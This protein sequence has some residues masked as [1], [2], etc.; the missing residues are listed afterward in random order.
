MPVVLAPRRV[1]RSQI[2]AQAGLA[3]LRGGL[4]PRGLKDRLARLRRHTRPNVEMPVLRH[5]GT[6]PA[7]PH[8]ACPLAQ[9]L[10]LRRRLLPVRAGGSTVGIDS[11][12]R[13][14]SSAR[15]H[16]LTA[17]FQAGRGIDFA[18]RN[19]RITSSGRTNKKRLAST[20]T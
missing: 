3:A 20:T 6:G 2:R 15:A 9:R 13:A 14:R 17:R 5:V 11:P 1:P 12:A 16:S 4:G 8:L 10:K 7:L 19:H 18:S